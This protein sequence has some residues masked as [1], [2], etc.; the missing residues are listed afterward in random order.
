M[1]HC[2]TWNVIL[3]SGHS[4]EINSSTINSQLINCSRD[5]SFSKGRR[6]GL[7]R[8]SRR[9]LGLARAEGPV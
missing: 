9:S 5:Q 8:P 6:L 3:E 4:L 2:K 1:G 7:G